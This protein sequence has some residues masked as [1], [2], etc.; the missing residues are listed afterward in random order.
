MKIR[1][2]NTGGYSSELAE[3]YLKLDNDFVVLYFEKINKY[4]NDNN[5]YLDEYSHHKIT[6]TPVDDETEV[7]TLKLENFDE[8]IT[9]F[10]VVKIND[11]QACEVGR[12]VYFKAKS[13]DLKGKLDLNSFV[14]KGI[15][16]E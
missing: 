3:K 15:F 5:C 11:L 10:S 4:D 13:F 16:Q 9:K 6:I 2:R 12:N 1:K 14:K 8:K 7:F